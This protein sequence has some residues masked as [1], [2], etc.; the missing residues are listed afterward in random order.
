MYL[1]S[2]GHQ[3]DCTSIFL[4]PCEKVPQILSSE[5]NAPKIMAAPALA[6]SGAGSV[7]KLE[8]IGGIEEDGG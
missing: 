1:R 5:T 3:I 6:A 8:E 2:E 4:R 7:E